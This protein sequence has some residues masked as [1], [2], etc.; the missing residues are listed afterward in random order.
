MGQAA[1][2]GQAIVVFDLHHLVPLPEHHVAIFPFF[3]LMGR[4]IQ[5]LLQALIQIIDPQRALFH[6][7]QHLDILQ[8]LLG[9]QLRGLAAIEGNKPPDHRLLLLHGFK[10]EILQPFQDGHLAL[11]DP[12]GVG[13]DGAAAGLAEDLRK[14]YHWDLAGIHHIPQYVSRPHGGQLVTVSHHDQPGTGGQGP[15]QGGHEGHVHHAHLVHNH[16]IRQQGVLRV[17]AKAPF[18]I[19]VFQQPVDGAG[20]PAGGLSH[21]FG[22][23][24]RRGA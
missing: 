21:A 1:G 16:H 13:D 11:V 4:G 12:V 23:P 9:A 7:G 19:A 6:G 22:R 10:A 3:F 8:R 20:I 5:G 15:E 18:P 24:P 2:P 17:P 14:A